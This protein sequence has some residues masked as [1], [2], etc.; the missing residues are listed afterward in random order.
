[1]ERAGP[2]LAFIRSEIRELNLPEELIYLPVI[3]S[4]YLATAVS[5]SGATGLWQFMR[6]SID[7]FD[8]KVTDWIDERRDFWKSTQGA[9]RKLNDNYRILG[10][11]PLALAAYNAGLGAI[12]SIVRIT[13]IRD[14]WTLSA[15]NQIRTETVHYV[16]K[17]LAAAYVLT[18]ARQYGIVLWPEDPDWTRIPVNRPVD[19][20]L[21][22]VEADIDVAILKMANRELNYD[23]TP[24]ERNYLLKVQ[25]QDAAKVS[26]ALARDMPLINYYIHTIRSGDTLLALANHYGITVDQIT[27]MNPTVQ[28][29]NLRIGSTLM[30]PALREVQSMPVTSVGSLNFSGSYEVKRGD[31]LW[32][33]ALAHGVTPEALAEANNMALNDILREGRVLKTPIR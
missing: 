30:I 14:Y 4:G 32:S 21:L 31:S 10:D 28:A 27:A 24:P 33:I 2:Y 6:N 15:R 7:P 12:Q 25:A 20:N 9:L 3:E 22:A 17:L 23:I 1:M 8:M 16:P 18:N 19:L 5:S 11:W 29:R 26:T 13:G